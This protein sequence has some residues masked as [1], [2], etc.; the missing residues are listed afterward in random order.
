MYLLRSGLLL[1]LH[2]LCRPVSKSV[3]SVGSQLLDPS[4]RCW[5]LILL[6]NPHIVVLLL[7]LLL[8]MLS[9]SCSLAT[10][11]CSLL[12]GALLTGRLSSVFPL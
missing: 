11:V 1:L 2:S 12:L 5:W 3:S 9:R 10:I 6:R 4:V 7:R 8:L